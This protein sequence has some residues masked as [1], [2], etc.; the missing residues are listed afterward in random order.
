MSKAEEELQKVSDTY[1][2]GT[3]TICV[4]LYFRKDDEW[5]MWNEKH[6]VIAYQ[7][8]F[9]EIL[10]GEASVG[11]NTYVRSVDMTDMAYK[12]IQKNQK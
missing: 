5:D 12:K 2:D 3:K 8:G 4:L 9:Q 7:H 6:L 10:I 1:S 11:T